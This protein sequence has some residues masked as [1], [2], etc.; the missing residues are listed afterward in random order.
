MCSMIYSSCITS[1]SSTAVQVSKHQ[2]ELK[3]INKIVGSGRMMD[4]K[5]AALEEKLKMEQDSTKRSLST[6]DNQ[7]E[8]L[9]TT[10]GQTDV[11]RL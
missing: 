9:N 5:K 2:S 3:D 11:L 7:I 4:K 1:S 6:N 10:I 8:Q